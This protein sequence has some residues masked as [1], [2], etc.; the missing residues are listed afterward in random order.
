MIRLE[1]S[2]ELLLLWW[3]PVKLVGQLQDELSQNQSIV[4]VPTAV[5]VDERLAIAQTL[6]RVKASSIA[7]EGV[8]RLT[9]DRAI[10]TAQTLLSNKYHHPH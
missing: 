7:N 3:N 6:N 9:F 1:V 4:G 10:E 5:Q 8:V 2:G